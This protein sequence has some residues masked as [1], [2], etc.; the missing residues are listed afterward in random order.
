VDAEARITQL[1]SLPG[2]QLIRSKAW[3]EI[4]EQGCKDA[5]FFPANQ[6]VV[7]VTS[8]GT[9][10]FWDLTTG[11]HTRSVEL[12][13]PGFFPLG[14]S[15]DNR[16]LLGRPSEGDA[17]LWD[18][19]A[20]RRVQ[21][22]SDFRSSAAFSPDGHWL[23]YDTP[24]YVIKVWDLAAN[25][26]KATLKGHSWRISSLAFSPNGR[27]LASGGIEAEARLWSVE[28]G[29]PLLVP[30]TGHLSGVGAVAF[31]GDGK[32]LITR[33]DEG[34]TR[35]W[36]V[37]TG[38]EMLLFQDVVMVFP[39]HS[40]SFEG[41]PGDKMLVWRERQGPIRVTTLPALAEIDAV[42]KAKPRWP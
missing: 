1:W 2:G 33:G 18:L 16:W 28:S 29:Q 5:Q 40:A 9:V 4:D 41:N 11:A 15:L 39:I 19:R 31:S 21:Q 27:L 12:G 13:S 35:W 25:R 32:T 6:A 7:G 42:E 23:A 3:H 22:F 37:A 8:N 20:G 30:L 17:L 14:L 26:E 36:Q 10:H 24:D 34:T 38:R